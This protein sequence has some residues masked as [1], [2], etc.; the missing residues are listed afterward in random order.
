MIKSNNFEIFGK[1]YGTNNP[2]KVPLKFDTLEEELNFVALNALLAFGSGWRDE[3][4]EA[5]NRVSLR[6]INILANIK[7][8]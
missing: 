4:H 8:I 3:L 2:L 6:N 5:C 7:E 1:Y